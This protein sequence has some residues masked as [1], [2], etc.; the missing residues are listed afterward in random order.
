MRGPLGA[1]TIAARQPRY[2]PR[3]QRRARPWHHCPVLIYWA[4]CEARAQAGERSLRRE[5]ALII[6]YCTASRRSDSHP[7]CARANAGCIELGSAIKCPR[8]MHRHPVAALFKLP[9]QGRPKTRRACAT[10]SIEA[11]YPRPDCS[12]L[13]GSLMHARTQLTLY[14]HSSYVLRLTKERTFALRCGRCTCNKA[15]Q[16]NHSLVPCC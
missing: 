2:A 8:R 11:H 6:R 1:R 16:R 10:A 15:T 7:P 3:A 13:S 5:Y 4:Q 12:M 9:C 14:Q